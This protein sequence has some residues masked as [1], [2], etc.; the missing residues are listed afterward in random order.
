MELPDD[1]WTVRNADG[2]LRMASV[3]APK[4]TFELPQI[5]EY[6]PTE[7]G[8]VAVPKMVPLWSSQRGR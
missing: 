5:V 2:Y 3:T 4:Q 8:C 1:L 7:D 6:L